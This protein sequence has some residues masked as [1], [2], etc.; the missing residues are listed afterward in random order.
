MAP[1]VPP[2][3]P[4]IARPRT[5]DADS[6][7]AATEYYFARVQ[8]LNRGFRGK[9]AALRTID[10]ERMHRRVKHIT[11]LY[12]RQQLHCEPS[13]FVFFTGRRLLSYTSTLALPIIHF[14]NP[15][16]PMPAASRAIAACL[17]FSFSSRMSPSIVSTATAKSKKAWLVRFKSNGLSVTH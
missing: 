9:V 2:P 6:L 7:S 3:S 15:R 13:L 11:R 10:F 8:E 12:K 16:A 5:V 1:P 4:V 14:P 17:A